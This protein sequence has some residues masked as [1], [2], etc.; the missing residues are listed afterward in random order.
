MRKSPQHQHSTQNHLKKYRPFRNKKMTC[1]LYIDGMRQ[2]IDEDVFDQMAQTLHQSNNTHNIHTT[3]PDG[4][5]DKKPL[6]PKYVQKY[7]QKKLTT[8]FTCPNC[9]RTISSKSNL[10]KH[11]QTNRCMNSRCH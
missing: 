3:A 6:D 5:Y 4:T 8:P 1:Y 9:G 7:Y 2:E 10:S 11:R